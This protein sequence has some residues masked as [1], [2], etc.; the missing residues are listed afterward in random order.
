MRELIT[1]FHIELLNT[2]PRTSYAVP[3]GVGVW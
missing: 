3:R 2:T 1:S